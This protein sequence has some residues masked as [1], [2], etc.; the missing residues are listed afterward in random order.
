MVSNSKSKKIPSYQYNHIELS[1][2]LAYT[3]ITKNIK[4]LLLLEGVVIMVKTYDKS[5][6]WYKKLY[7]VL[8]MNVMIPWKACYDFL[9]IFECYVQ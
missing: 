7:Y 4:F 2:P 9:S 5:P 1:I 6:I 8:N 3:I